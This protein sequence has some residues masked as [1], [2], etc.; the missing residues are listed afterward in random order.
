M[1]HLYVLASN[2]FWHFFELCIQQELMGCESRSLAMIKILQRDV[3]N[4]K[5]SNKGDG[6]PFLSGHYL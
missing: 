3:I 1:Y 2:F 5:N 4:N 6:W